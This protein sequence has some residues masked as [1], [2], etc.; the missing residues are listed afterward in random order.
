MQPRIDRSIDR[1]QS[2]HVPLA[3][4]SST[5]PPPIVRRPS[6]F[7]DPAVAAANNPAVA[8]LIRR[9]PVVTFGVVVSSPDPRIVDGVVVAAHSLTRSTD[10][11]VRTSV[12][13][14]LLSTQSSFPLRNVLD[15]VVD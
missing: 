9:S 14:L 4:S 15:R 1:S 5:V 6:P 3:F 10:A 13:V 8:A 12:V 11:M 2:S 7:L